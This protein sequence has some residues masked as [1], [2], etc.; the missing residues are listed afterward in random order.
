MD[1]IERL[2]RHRLVHARMKG[3]NEEYPWVETAI[4]RPLGD[5]PAV[6]GAYIAMYVADDDELDFM[7][8]NV[9]GAV[10]QHD[11]ALAIYT[12]DRL[13]KRVRETMESTMVWLTEHGD[14][15]FIPSA[16]DD[17]E[18]RLQAEALQAAKRHLPDPELPVA[19]ASLHT[20]SGTHRTY[21]GFHVMAQVPPYPL[22]EVFRRNVALGLIGL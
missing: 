3:P 7:Y 5:K 16:G 17:L 11:F 4:S 8:V 12:L 15:V 13:P 19:F 6:L 1:D 22:W 14:F 21:L 2:R 20:I 9:G 10:R 18:L